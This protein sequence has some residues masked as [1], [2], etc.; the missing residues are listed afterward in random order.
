MKEIR[1]LQNGVEPIV[2]YDDDNTKLSTYSKKISSLLEIGNVAILETSTENVILRPQQI[3]SIRV[4][5]TNS[6]PKSES[7]PQ[8]GKKYVDMIT[9]G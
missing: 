7:K 4:I 3:V 8:S 1:I 9:D 6:I 5:D 2:I